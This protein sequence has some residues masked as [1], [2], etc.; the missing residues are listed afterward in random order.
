M[1]QL[2]VLEVGG[3]DLGSFAAVFYGDVTR[4]SRMGSWP[5]ALEGE[6]SNCCGITQ[7]VEQKKQ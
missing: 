4:R 2:K 5:V 3:G 1:N 7:L 6:G